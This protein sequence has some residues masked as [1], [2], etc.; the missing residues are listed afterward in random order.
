MR[1]SFWIRRSALQH[2]HRHIVS[3]TIATGNGEVTA[4]KGLEDVV[5]ICTMSRASRNPNPRKSVCIVSF[6]H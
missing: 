6:A 4:V 2:L 1:N 5:S 3:L